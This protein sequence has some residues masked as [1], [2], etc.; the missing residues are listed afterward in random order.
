[1]IESLFREEKTG[2]AKPMSQVSALSSSEDAPKAFLDEE[3]SPLSAMSRLQGAGPGGQT[4]K[5]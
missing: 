4:Q 1:M 2:H 3:W 5:E